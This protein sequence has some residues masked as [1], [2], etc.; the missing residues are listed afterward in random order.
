MSHERNSVYV[1]VILIALLGVLLS[2]CCGMF[3]GYMAGGWQARTVVWRHARFES[4]RTPYS[5]EWVMPEEGEKPPSRSPLVA[6]TPESGIPPMEGPS[7]NEVVPDAFWEAGYSAGALLLEVNAGSPAQK[8][9]LR[10]GD[11][12]VAVDGKAL[13][14]EAILSDVIKSYEPGDK[15]KIDFWRREKDRSVDVTL[16]ENPEKSD[17]AYLGVLFVPIPPPEM[18]EEYD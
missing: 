4:Q 13:K 3:G 9:G 14:P 10:R 2:C 1:V 15:V 18:V 6:P 12:I 7:L 11:I 16:A 17:Q 5:P 8:A